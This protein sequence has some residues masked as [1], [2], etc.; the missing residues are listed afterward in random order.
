MII[1]KKRYFG[2]LEETFISSVWVVSFGLVLIGGLYLGGAYTDDL[3][4]L[5][6]VLGLNQKI[7]LVVLGL[8]TTSLFVWL[9]VLGCAE[10]TRDTSRKE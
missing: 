4:I 3:S 5:Y 1:R 8:I 9:I 10:C 7:F 6:I 2:W